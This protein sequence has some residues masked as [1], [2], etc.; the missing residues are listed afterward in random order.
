[1]Q[2]GPSPSAR[3]VPPHEAYLALGANLG[4]RLE[5]LRAACQRL[6]RRGVHVQARSA[7]YETDAV[8]DDLQPPYLNAVVRVRT[9]LAPE[10]L[11]ELGL[12]IER[13]LGRL[14][15]AERRWAPRPID[16]DL[17]L[18]DDRIARTPK[19]ELP[20]PRLLER[21]FV[22]VPLAAVARPGLRHPIHGTRLDLAPS[23]PAVRPWP[24]A[25]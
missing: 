23:D 17:L 7:V 11:L 9:H 21:S 13:S 4:R 15:T 5:T 24:Q 6:D 1:M 2:A 19:L 10:V 8:A 12:E 16:I 14:R 18:Y 3:G 25:L 22:R 20:H